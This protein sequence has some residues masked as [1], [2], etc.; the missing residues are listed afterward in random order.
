M[1][2]VAVF[3]SESVTDRLPTLAIVRGMEEVLLELYR[4]KT[5]ATIRLLEA[6]AQLEDGV[7]DATTPGTYGT[8]RETLH[9]LVR[10]EEGYLAAVS[11]EPVDRL[12]EVTVS[13]TELAR[14]IESYGP[15]WE[16]LAT[17]VAACARQITSG[18]GKWRMPAFVPMAQAIHHADAHRSQVFSILG[19]HKVEVAELGSDPDLDVWDHAISIEVMH[20]T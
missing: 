12:G 19:A 4:H 11:D 14:R 17:D 10:A 2:I 7:L 15:R 3:R 20:R 16:T 9:H 1:V 18:D 6:C 8:V 5:W 13:M